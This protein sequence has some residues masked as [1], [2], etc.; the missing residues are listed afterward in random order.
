M[1][2][3]QSVDLQVVLMFI[4]EQPSLFFMNL[5]STYSWDASNMIVELSEP[6]D[7]PE[8]FCP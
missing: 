5:W 7:T 3:V 8:L 4:Y 6:A 1:K 2:S